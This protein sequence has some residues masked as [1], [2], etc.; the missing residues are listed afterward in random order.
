MHVGTE[1]M[2]MHGLKFEK[3]ELQNENGL[4]KVAP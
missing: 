4:Q 1:A 3:E 2:A